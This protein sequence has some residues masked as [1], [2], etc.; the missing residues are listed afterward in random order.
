M[1]EALRQ[2]LAEFVVTVDRAG[3]LARG[4]QAVDALK[5]KLTE[6]QASFGKIKA[7]AQQTA[8]TLRGKIGGAIDAVRAGF[9]GGGGSGGQGLIASL[10]TVRN[11]LLAL[12]AG[13]AVHGVR[14]L[15]DNIGDVKDAAARLGVSTDDFQRLNLLATQSSTSVEGLG[16]AFRT[17]ATLAV[18]PTKESAAAFAKLGV[19]TKGA[20][21]QVKTSQELFFDVGEAL[22]GVAN[23]TERSALAQQILGRS[24]QQLKPIFASGTEAFR[25]Q[26]AALASMNVISADT[27]DQAE[28]LG[29]TWTTIGPSLLAA[30]EPL[31]KLLIPGLVKLTEWLIKGIEV[32]GKWLKNTDLTSAGLTLLAAVLSMKVVPGLRLMVGLGGGAV[33][34]LL[35]LA[36]AG[37]KALWSFARL[38]A[39]LLA[40]QDFIVFLQGGDSLLGRGLD[41]VFGEGAASGVLKALKDLTAAFVDLWKWILGDGA[42][43]K[44]KS[45]YR[46]LTDGIALMVHDMLVKLGIREGETGLQGKADF[47]A[48]KTGM[49]KLGRALGGVNPNNDFFQSMRA[50]QAARGGDI[51]AP[52][53]GQQHG[54]STPAPTNVD[55][56]GPRNVTVNMGSSATASDVARVA[57]VELERDRNATMAYVQ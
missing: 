41:A 27:I 9:N 19:S 4:N 5:L 21:G 53:G 20:N 23:E 24:A 3:E 48:G 36:G 18:N 56:S 22:S 30:S 17:L 15:V 45:L 7:P 14:R 55:A 49:G 25:A 34:S 43:D 52:G 29:D 8:Q 31:L 50:I 38:A 6:L 28:A 42:G 46:E 11:G 1:S 37:A 35:G 39:P 10:A 33:K 51:P 2:L 54:S 44:A 16:T 26:R 32:G 13:A 12:G 47:D 57:G 40:L